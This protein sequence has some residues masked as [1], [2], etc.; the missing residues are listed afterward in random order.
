[1]VIILC[2]CNINNKKD[3][4]ADIVKN[5]SQKINNT[6]ELHITFINVGKGDCTIIYN[7]NVAVM[8]DTGYNTTSDEV[9]NYLKK[10]KVNRLDALIISHFDKDHVGGASDIIKSIEINNIFFPDYQEDSKEYKRFI[11]ALKNNFN[12][13]KHIVHNN[14]TIEYSD[15]MMTLYA[16]KEKSYELD[17][18]YSLA[19]K[20]NC[21]NESFLFAGDAMELRIDELLKEDIS[22]AYLLKVPHHGF[23][24]KKSLEFIKF[25]N[26]RISIITCENKE[27]VSTGIIEEL[28]EIKSDIEYTCDGNISYTVNQQGVIQD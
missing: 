25:I 5:N 13:K 8:I 9:V 23:I 3:S 18:N 16:P 27:Q 24:C 28:Y 2:G 22:N 17:N 12:G 19:A 1:M 21:Y 14:M 4:S 26:P 10:I 20:I 6:N 7:D 15:I 11:K